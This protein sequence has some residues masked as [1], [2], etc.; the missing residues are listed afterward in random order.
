MSMLSFD[1]A[2]R[3][4]GWFASTASAGSFCLFC[5]NGVGGLPTFTNV[6]ELT[7]PPAGTAP[8]ATRATTT[9]G[10][11]GNRR[12]D[13]FTMETPFFRPC[14]GGEETWD[15]GGTAAGQITVTPTPTRAHSCRRT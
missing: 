5:E 15:T 7:A 9:A 1:P 13:R 12:E 3:T 2:T 10:R 14:G 11:R 8:A 6:S 4:F